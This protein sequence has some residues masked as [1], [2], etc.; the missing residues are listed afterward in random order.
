MSYWTVQEFTM[1]NFPQKVFEITGW[2][3]NR[4]KEWS[5]KLFCIHL[6]LG[7]K[8]MKK[9][10]M[11][12]VLISEFSHSNTKKTDRFTL[13]IKIWVGSYNFFSTRPC[14]VRKHNSLLFFFSTSHSSLPPRCKFL[15]NLL[16]SNTGDEE[17]WYCA[18]ACNSCG[19]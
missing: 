16:G 19:F 11:G 6:W 17:L 2:K 15:F 5:H 1:L 4:Q 13:Q 8:R 3:R 14:L 10:S 9:K 7:K 18:S 12:S